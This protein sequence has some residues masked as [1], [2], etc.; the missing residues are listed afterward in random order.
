MM[1]EDATPLGKDPIGLLGFTSPH[2]GQPW[3]RARPQR[4]TMRISSSALHRNAQL[5]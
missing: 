2:L 4:R 3:R 1:A 5:N